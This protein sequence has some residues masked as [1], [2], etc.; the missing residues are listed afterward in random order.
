VIF[1]LLPF[2]I[3]RGI[4]GNKDQISAIVIKWVKH[5]ICDGKD[6]SSQNYEVFL[7]LVNAK[8]RK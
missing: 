6:S 1:I 3:S 8:F 5:Y 2:L 7:Q 4:I